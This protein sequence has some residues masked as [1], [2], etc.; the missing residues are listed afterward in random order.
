M[1]KKDIVT[2]LLPIIAIIVTACGKGKSEQAAPVVDTIPMMVMQIQK[3]SRLYTAECRIHKIVTH[4][5]R[6]KLKGK[7]FNRDID[8]TLPLGSRKVAIPIDVT[9]KAYIDFAGFSERNISR[10]GQNI[11]ITLPDPRIVLTSS[12]IDHVGMKKY[13]ALTRSNFTDA[14]LSSYEQQGRQAVLDNIPETD[15]IAQARESA[16]TIL[17]PLVRQMGY[18]EENITINF[19]KDFDSADLKSVIDLNNAE[20]HGKER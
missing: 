16:A 10:Q 11:S 17:I 9:L 3:C 12:K 13:V 4:E 19:R 15:I 6:K 5:D 7:V 20:K 1:R 8:I 14:E 2:P 18:K